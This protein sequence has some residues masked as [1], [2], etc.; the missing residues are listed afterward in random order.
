MFQS[1]TLWHRP[2]GADHRFVW[3]AFAALAAL[4]F[5]LNAGETKFWQQND[6]A[7]FEKGSFENISLR[8]DGRMFL[9]P[10]AREVFDSKTPYLWAIATDSKGALYTAGGGDGSG[11]S[12]LFEIAPD[13]KTRTVTELE[14]LEIHAIAIDKND[15]IYAATDPDGKIYKVARDGK[16]AVYYD[17]HAKYIWALAFD[18]SG[19]LFVA[20][21]DQGEIHRVTPDGRGSV[22]FRT[23]ETHARSLA[24]DR[25]GNLI[26]GTEPGGLILRISPAAAGFVLYQAQSG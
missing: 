19:N 12:K 18:N 14:G 7:D 6:Q 10:S 9:A 2:R 15:Q 13:G 3:S 8:S 20:T 5:N 23:E 1:C 4:T 24:I 11:R 21:G 26:V 25:N 17:P 22:F 16:C